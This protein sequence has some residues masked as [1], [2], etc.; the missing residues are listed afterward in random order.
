MCNGKL[1]QVLALFITPSYVIAATPLQQGASETSTCEGSANYALLLMRS[2]ESPSASSSGFCKRSREASH[3]AC[4]QEARAPAQSGPALARAEPGIQL[5][6]TRSGQLP[7]QVAG[8]TALSISTQLPAP[9]RNGARGG[10]PRK[11]V[12]MRSHGKGPLA[13]HSNNLYIR[14]GWCGVGLS[15]CL[16]GCC[17][18][19]A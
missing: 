6:C 18:W 9:A 17:C 7:S 15:K 11:G 5:G 19:L 12:P 1:Y 8:P 4:L 3:G 13:I 16:Q 10:L 2:T 14:I